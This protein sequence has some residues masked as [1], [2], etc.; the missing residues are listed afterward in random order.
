MASL[1]QRT[2]P[3]AKDA[4]K[5]PPTPPPGP[6]IDDYLA[7]LLARASHLISAEFHV[8]VHRAR[9]PVMQWRV[10]AALADGQS[11]SIGEVAAIVLTPQSTLTRVAERMVKAGLLRRADDVA[12][13]RITRIELTAAGLE[14]ARTLV[15]QANE[16]EAAVLGALSAADAADA[17]T[18]K[19]ILRRLIEQHALLATDVAD[20]R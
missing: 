12:D 2:R 8:L 19:R 17:A 7:Y 15:A 3:A 18:L 11:T 20:Q 9:L 5:P 4:L 16:H 13:R 14:L 10:M 1:A 6:F